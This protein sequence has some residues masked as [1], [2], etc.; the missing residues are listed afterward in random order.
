MFSSFKNMSMTGSQFDP[1]FDD[2]NNNKESSFSDSLSDL[3]DDEGLMASH[4]IS[5]V[6]AADRLKKSKASSHCRWSQSDTVQRNTVTSRDR[7][8]ISS[9]PTNNVALSPKMSSR[10][11]QRLPKSSF[12]H[13][14]DVRTNHRAQLDRDTDTR[15]KSEHYVTSTSRR[16]T[17]RNNSDRHRSSRSKGTHRRS[18]DPRKTVSDS[19]R[20]TPKLSIS[21]YLLGP[22]DQVA[23]TL[24]DND[25]AVTMAHE[26][27]PPP[28]VRKLVR[29][30][31]SV[32]LGRSMSC[33][34]SI[35]QR[36]HCNRAQ[37]K[38]TAL[39]LPKIKQGLAPP[40]PQR[41]PVNEKNDSSLSDDSSSSSSSESIIIHVQPDTTKSTATPQ[42]FSKAPV[43]L[44]DAH[45]VLCLLSSELW[46]DDKAI[47]AG[48]LKQLVMLCQADDQ[49]KSIFSQAGYCSLCGVF[50]KWYQEKEILIAGFRLLQMTSENFA[51]GAF[52]CGVLEC[53][54]AA[55]NNF[56][57]DGPLQAAACGALATIVSTSKSGPSIKLVVDL[58]GPV[59]LIK[60]MES[61]PDSIEVQHKATMAF[62]SMARFPQLSERLEVEASVVRALSTEKFDVATALVESS[63]A[64][65]NDHDVPVR[66]HIMVLARG[67]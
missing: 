18:M 47:V 9:D 4:A 2:W 27:I 19:T 7:R 5:K 25:E 3:S 23:E 29:R 59:V 67:A 38:A 12:S 43:V 45:P 13:K 30:N 24:G 58:Q 65:D 21:S 39:V 14:D 63:R 60:A 48:G 50:R 20:R 42:Q 31:S 28:R 49:N 55:M 15:A 61:F 54:V 62:L 26:A 17:S 22:S 56:V 32:K 44:A 53:I 11:S 57:G 8:R 40:P 37:A 16:D 66:K 6:E 52:G 33:S 46:S 10:N 36:A 34:R 51:V 35:I 41:Q 64:E 1:S